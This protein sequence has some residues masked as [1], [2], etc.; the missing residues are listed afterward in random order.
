VTCQ[1][2]KEREYEDAWDRAQR[3][4]ADAENAIGELADEGHLAS[5]A[6]KFMEAGIRLASDN[7]AAARSLAECTREDVATGAPPYSLKW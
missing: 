3:G 4:L 6:L 1:R 7:I 5:A 2:C